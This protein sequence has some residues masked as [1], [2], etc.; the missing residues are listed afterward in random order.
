MAHFIPTVKVIDAEN[1]A[2]LFAKNVFRLHGVPQE[3]ISDRG[4]QFASRFWKCF[5]TLLGSKMCLTT[6]FRPQA[7]PTERVNQ[8]MEQYIRIF[9]NYQQNDWLDMLYLG[10]FAYNN[11]VNV[12]RKYSP[13]FANYAFHSRMD[14]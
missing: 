6:S 7:D 5:F 1:T 13:F 2:I 8:V 3:I 9:T 12:S 10:E 4:P 14:G 11:A